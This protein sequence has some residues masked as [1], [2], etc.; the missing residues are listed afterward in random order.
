RPRVRACGRNERASM[1][2]IDM[3]ALRHRG[4]RRRR[5]KR[6][7]ARAQILLGLGAA[8]GL[9]LATAELL[10]LGGTRS[11]L[12]SAAVAS[13]GGTP[14]R[15]DDYERALAALASDRRTPLDDADRRHVLDRMI[16]EELL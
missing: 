10:A 7:G 9:V 12:P 3:R 4:T 8:L 6:E 13:V 5:M 16:D 1:L 15:R 2:R 11:S 14:I